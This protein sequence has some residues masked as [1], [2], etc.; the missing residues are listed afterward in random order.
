MAR[1]DVLRFGLA[2]CG[3]ALQYWLDFAAE[4]KVEIAGREVNFAGLRL[5]AIEAVRSLLRRIRILSITG[6]LSSFPVGFDRFLPGN[7]Q[8]SLFPSGRFTVP[9]S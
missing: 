9:S 7:T 6:T 2:T 3:A 4:H 5:V 1:L 8:T